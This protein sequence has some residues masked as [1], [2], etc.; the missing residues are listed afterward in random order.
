LSAPMQRTT[1]STPRPSDPPPLRPLHDETDYEWALREVERL[2][3][4]PA[5]SPEDERLQVLV[6]LIDAYE[7]EH[8]PIDPP[9]PVDAI[10]FRMEQRN[11]AADDVAALLGVSRQRVQAMLRG[12]PLTL[13]MIRLLVERLGISADVL[14][15]DPTGSAA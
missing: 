4:A 2:W 13:P 15:R 14:V 8:H 7:R 9:D 12:R 1:A 3:D 6:L 11:L 10:R 5:G